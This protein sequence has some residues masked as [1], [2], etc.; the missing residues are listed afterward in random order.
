MSDPRRPTVIQG[1]RIDWVTERVGWVDLPEGQ[2]IG[3]KT[4]ALCLWNSVTGMFLPVRPS[5]A[6][7]LVF[8]SAIL[9]LAADLKEAHE[10]IDTL[11]SARLKAVSAGG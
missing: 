7:Q 5:S 9:F 11:L 10:R 4:R 8:M 2:L 1:Q 3:Q 6:D